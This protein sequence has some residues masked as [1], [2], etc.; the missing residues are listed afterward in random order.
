MPFSVKQNK[1]SIPLQLFCFFLVFFGW[2]F[3]FFTKFIHL[4]PNLEHIYKSGPLADPIF[5]FD[6]G[7]AGHFCVHS[8]L[9]HLIFTNI[10]MPCLFKNNLFSDLRCIY[11]HY[12]GPL[13]FKC[14]LSSTLLDSPCSLTCI[15]Y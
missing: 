4:L 6:A 7:S 2:L 8:C 10:S 12:K 14:V 3:F 11:N 9:R 15:G 13:C 1:L 5:S